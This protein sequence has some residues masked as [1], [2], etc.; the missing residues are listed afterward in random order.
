MDGQHRLQVYENNVNAE[1][2]TGDLQITEL[3]LANRL[4]TPASTFSNNSLLFFRNDQVQVQAANVQLNGSEAK[5]GDAL[6]IP[7]SVPAPA[8][9]ELGFDEGMLTDQQEDFKIIEAEELSRITKLI[10]ERMDLM[11]KEAT[12]ANKT[13]NHGYLDSDTVAGIAIIE[14]LRQILL[15]YPA[16]FGTKSSPAKMSALEPIKVKLTDYAKVLKA[17]PKWMTHRHVVELRKKLDLMLRRE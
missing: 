15:K 10:N 14:K 5:E 1:A 2:K 17:K 3:N 9:T 12:Q 16:A 4:G 11:I 13:A 7:R 8:F 6:V